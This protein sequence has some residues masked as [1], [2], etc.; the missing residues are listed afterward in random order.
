MAHF[1]AALARLFSAGML[2]AMLPLAVHGA[3][4]SPLLPLRDTFPPGSIDSSERADQALTAVDARRALMQSDYVERERECYKTFLANNCIDELKAQRRIQEADFDSVAL[5]AN[6]FKRNLSDQHNKEQKAQKAADAK[7]NAAQDASQ[8]AQ[9]RL[10]YESKQVTADQKLSDKVTR[11]AQDAGNA[12]A[13]SSKVANNTQ[14]QKDRASK[15]LQANA[16]FQQ[17][18]A[19]Q[20]KKEDD[21]ASRRDS[22]ARHRADKASDRAKRASEAA[23]NGQPP[24]PGSKTVIPDPHA[25]MLPGGAAPA[26]SSASGNVSGAGGAAAAPT[27]ATPAQSSATTKP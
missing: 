1:G 18:E 15:D 20:K 27:A 5:E 13:Y 7:A 26:A 4:S 24:P 23:S 9:N 17:A 16:K 12:A 19:D 22:L 3:G 25:P 2:I 21:A 8:R 6:R 14:Q 10:G 11:S